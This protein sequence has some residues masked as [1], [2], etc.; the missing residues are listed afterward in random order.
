MTSHELPIGYRNG[1]ILY[2]DEVESGL[3]CNCVCPKCG[4]KLVAKK[5][6][7]KRHH[8]AHYQSDT[9]GEV[10]DFGAETAL[11]L[12]AKEIIKNNNQILLPSLSSKI[13]YLGVVIIKE[14]KEIP[15]DKVVEEE[16]FNEIKPDII[17][18]NKAKRLIIEIAV[19]H[20]SDNNKIKKI[21]HYGISA[22]EI[23]LKGLL[24]KQIDR[25]GLIKEVLKN[26][27]NRKWLFNSKK[28]Q[29]KK[30]YIDKHQDEINLKKDQE[31]KKRIKKRNYEES[32]YKRGKLYTDSSKKRLEYIKEE[33]D[34][35]NKHHKKILK[36]NNKDNWF[37]E[38]CPKKQNEGKRYANVKYE[39]KECKYYQ[40][41]RYQDKVIICIDSNILEDFKNNFN[42]L[43][44]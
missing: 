15:Y 31:E 24:N 12:A 34:L 6:E 30:E 19:T 41:N 39:C 14:E 38:E 43:I 21:K 29:F 3:N 25:N 42:Y 4:N 11:H 5:G 17:V 23:D 20:F 22:I 13:D 1:K 8:F 44:D 40:G 18:Y 36:E 2:I 9:I 26:A 16:Q 32:I 7:K 10:C 33:E 27:K 28:E 35:F 37:V